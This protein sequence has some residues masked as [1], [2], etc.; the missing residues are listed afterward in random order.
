MTVRVD[1]A[2]AVTLRVPVR[3]ADD[4]ACSCLM[5]P[6]CAHRA[7]VLSIAPPADAEP[8]GEEPPRRR[9][10]RARQAIAGAGAALPAAGGATAP[11]GARAAG[12]ATAAGFSA[13]EVAAAD[14]LWVAGTALLAKGLRRCRCRA[15]G[16]TAAG[17]P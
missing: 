17:G 1:D 2:T 11:A 5:S 15:A 6:R 3:G 14:G 13:A 8:P 16:D 7:A 12:G 4:V 10:R 9:R